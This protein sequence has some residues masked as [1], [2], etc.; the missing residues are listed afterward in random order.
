[1]TA[2]A[3]ARSVAEL[4]RLT[5]RC[6]RDGDPSAAMKNADVRDDKLACRGFAMTSASGMPFDFAQGQA[7]R[8]EV[9]FL[10]VRFAWGTGLGGAGA[11]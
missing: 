10:A 4:L 2:N 6:S 8:Q 9:Y 7:F 11:T 5:L 1:M 3:E